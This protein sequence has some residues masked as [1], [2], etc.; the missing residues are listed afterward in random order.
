LDENI[1]IIKKAVLE[2]SGEIGLEENAE[3]TKYMVV[4]RQQNVV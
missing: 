3:I 2:A 4:S 1:N